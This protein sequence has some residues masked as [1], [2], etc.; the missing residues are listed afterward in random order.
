MVYNGAAVY[1]FRQERFLWQCAIGDNAP[2]II[3]R[4]AEEYPDIGV[5]VLRGNTV[6]VPFLNEMEQWH[7]DLEHVPADFTPLDDIPRDGWLKVLFAVPSGKAGR[8]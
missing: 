8:A 2:W 5:E 7:L 3:K 4:I 6:Y 1:D